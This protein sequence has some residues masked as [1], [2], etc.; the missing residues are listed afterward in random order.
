MKK[1]SLVLL[2]LIGLGLASIAQIDTDQ[3]SLDISKAD[4]A[5]MQKLGAFLWKKASVV[6]VDGEEKAN[7]LNEI[8]IAA[9]G[10]IDIT[11][12]DSKS[13]VKKK[14]GV[15]GKIQQST[16]QSNT[17]YAQGAIEHAL[18]YTYMTK[19]QL[20]DFFG[21]ADITEKD[22]VIEASASDV[23]V[24]GDN[25]TVKVESATK[26]FLY[27]KF[28]STMGEDP[29][30]GEISYAKFTSGISHVSTSTLKLPAKKAVINSKNKDYVQKVQ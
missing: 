5:N 18:A 14:R 27:K 20:L 9:D 22:G 28:S 1:L 11:N 23:L 25:L 29:L 19:G 26:L 15:R 4:A 7:T 17:E 6:T 13:T 30:S 16:A 21:K 12:L 3:L 2:I 24:K 8:S 10:T